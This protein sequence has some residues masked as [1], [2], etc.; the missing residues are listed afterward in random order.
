M[1]ETSIGACGQQKTQNSQ[2]VSEVNRQTVPVEDFFFLFR[3]SH[4]NLLTFALGTM[5]LL[6]S[7]GCS[8]GVPSRQQRPQNKRH[9]S[10][11]H[12][13]GIVPEKSGEAPG[14]VFLE[15]PGIGGVQTLI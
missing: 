2:M 7:C 10:G 8:S 15:E 6:C 3:C 11:F 13:G 14:F 1:K 5:P 4:R 12:N 9:D